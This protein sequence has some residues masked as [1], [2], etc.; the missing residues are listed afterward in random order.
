MIV[1]SLFG[2]EINWKII[3]PGRQGGWRR[4]DVLDAVSVERVLLVLGGRVEVENG[5][6][7]TAA[8]A[9]GRL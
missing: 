5:R 6:A 7:E 3:G 2:E 4:S 8:E 1:V 9:A